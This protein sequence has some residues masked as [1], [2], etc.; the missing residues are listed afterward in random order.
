MRVPQLFLLDRQRRYLDADIALVED[1]GTVRL[2]ALLERDPAAAAA[3]LTALGE[4]LRRMH[5]TTGPHYGKVALVA[6]GETPQARRSEVIIADRALAQLDTAAARD[7]RLAAA[8]GRIAAHVRELAA[9]I[10]QRATY[11]LVHGE[12]GPDHVLITPRGEPV[13]IDFEGLVHFDIEWDHAWSQMRF[14]DAYPALRPVELDTDRLALYRYAQ[15]LSLIEAHLRIADTDFR[16]ATGCSD[17]RST[18]SAK[19]SPRSAY[20]PDPA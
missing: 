14:G 17:W 12:L 18:T 4:A 9:T 19:H 15:V 3:P 2:E 13:V 8:H 20:P 5:T 7:A 11:G 16:T 1:A 6:R 10:T